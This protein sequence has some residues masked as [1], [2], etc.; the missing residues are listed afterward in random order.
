M[1]D[2]L[3]QLAAIGEATPQGWI[4]C[5]LWAGALPHSTTVNAWAYQGWIFEGYDR[6]VIW[7]EGDDLIVAAICDA[8]ADWAGNRWG[9]LVRF[10]AL[11]PDPRFGGAINVRATQTIFGEGDSAVVLAQH[12]Q[13][14]AAYDLLIAALP[15]DPDVELAGVW[16]TD[17]AFAAHQQARRL[18][19][20]REWTYGVEPAL[21]DA[22]GRIRPQ[23]SV[24]LYDVPEGTRTYY[25]RSAA[26]P[27]GTHNATFENAMIRNVA[28]GGTQQTVAVGTSGRLAWVFTTEAIEPGLADYPSGV[29]R[30][31]MDVTSAGVDIV[32]GLLTLGAM[33]GHFAVVDAGLTSDLQIFTQGEPAFQ[34]AGLHIATVPANPAAGATGD[35]WE[36]LIAAQRLTGHGN[37]DI[38][39]RFSADCFA[40]GPWPG[41]GAPAPQGVLAEAV[42]ITSLEAEVAEMVGAVLPLAVEIR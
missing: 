13:G 23:R 37:Q 15:I 41:G 5:D 29:Y 18:P 12:G 38:T 2:L 40:D 33:D 9:R 19:S 42:A 25:L 3:I 31:Q 1:R 30:V 28:G 4:G 20:W 27:T 16:L 7:R 21:I 36:I 14:V 26:L 10:P 32:F 6:G 24:G 34:G 35:R 11:A 22:T 39:L 17:E 8:S